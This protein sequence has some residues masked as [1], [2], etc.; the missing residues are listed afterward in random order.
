[1]Y[2]ATLKQVLD[3]QNGRCSNDR[4]DK[5]TIYEFIENNSGDNKNGNKE[6]TGRSNTEIQ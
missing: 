4:Y 3:S 5:C 1:M 2:M 6:K